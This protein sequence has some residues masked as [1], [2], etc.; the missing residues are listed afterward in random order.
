MGYIKIYSEMP[1]AQKL[2]FTLWLSKEIITAS[3]PQHLWVTPVE[4]ACRKGIQR[5]QKLANDCLTSPC[6]V[7]GARWLI[8]TLTEPVENPWWYSTAQRFGDP[9]VGRSSASFA[10][11]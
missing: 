4:P 5:G 8:I 11:H 10:T 9:L 2:R 1:F 7:Q 6:Q 3:M